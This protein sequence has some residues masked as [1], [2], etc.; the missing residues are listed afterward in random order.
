MIFNTVA[1]LF[2]VKDFEG[3]KH[4]SAQNLVRDIDFVDC[5][6][7]AIAPRLEGHPAKQVLL[8]FK[9][10]VKPLFDLRGQNPLCFQSLPSQNQLIN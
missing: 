1:S 3:Y 10:Q 5:R 8:S 2:Y 4:D 9:F 6:Q 7:V